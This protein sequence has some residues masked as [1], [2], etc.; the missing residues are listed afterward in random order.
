MATDRARKKERHR[1]K[2]KKRQEEL[3]RATQRSPFQVLQGG[4]PIECFVNPNWREQ[5]MAGIFVLK[6]LK[7]GG[8]AMGAFLVDLLC[9]GLK[10]CWGRLEISRSEFHELVSDAACDEVEYEPPVHTDIETAK[11][12]VAG[13]I[14]FTRQNRFRLP[15]RFERWIALLG[16]NG[17]EKDADLTDFGV[18]GDPTRLLYIGQ[19]EGLR[20]LLIGE[21]VEQAVKR[22]GIQFI[23][24]IDPETEDWDEIELVDEDDDEDLIGDE[25]DDVDRIDGEDDDEASGEVVEEGV[26]MVEEAFL[27]A[28]R[29]WCFQRGVVP[30]P[31][32]PVVLDLVMEAILQFDPEADDG[33]YPDPAAEGMRLFDRAVEC[34]GEGL[35]PELNAAL[36]QLL[37]FVHSFKTGADLCAALGMPQGCS[38]PSL[39]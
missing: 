10:D 30:H 8:C 28:I 17:S 31:N 7:G 13:A 23:F 9:C 6:Q 26:S 11:R 5:G 18:D 15:K 34:Q 39:Q 3:R 16:L 20:K 14:R 24:G 2:R 27:G 22:L 32:L 36:A 4:A 12:L 37:E 35:A 33:E 21:T 25:D 1:L 19:I 38:D 29:R